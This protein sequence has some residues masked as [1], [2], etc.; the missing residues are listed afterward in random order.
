MLCF[1]NFQW[2]RHF[3]ISSASIRHRVHCV[4]CPPNEFFVFFLPYWPGL[5][6]VLWVICMWNTCDS[7]N[8]ACLR[9]PPSLVD[10]FRCF[11]HSA[12]TAE[13]T[14][15]TRGQYSFS[16]EIWIFPYFVAHQLVLVCSKNSSRTHDGAIWRATGGE[17]WDRKR[18]SHRF[19]NCS[20]SN[21]IAD[22]I[23]MPRTAVKRRLVSLGEQLWLKAVVMFIGL[24]VTSVSLY[25]PEK[26]RMEMA[27]RGPFDSYDSN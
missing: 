10:K 19:R 17:K 21:I 20:F 25:H 14:F 24:F 3:I 6:R 27:E 13:G 5:Y 7:L 16:R 1:F 9:V 26:R 2:I 15:R 12:V 23:S 8:C 22:S 11:V 4:L 18:E